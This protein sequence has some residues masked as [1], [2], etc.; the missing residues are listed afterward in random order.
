MVVLY[1]HLNYQDS[2]ENFQNSELITENDII[3]VP[4]YIFDYNR[5]TIWSSQV[6]DVSLSG[7]DGPPGEMLRTDDISGLEM[8]LGSSAVLSVLAAVTTAA[9]LLPAPA[10]LG[11]L[12]G[13]YQHYYCLTPHTPQYL[14]HLT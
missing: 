8:M 9:V 10:W 7:W 12:T 11:L 1:R 5:V 6:S 3:D 13:Y 14:P 4:S 2:F